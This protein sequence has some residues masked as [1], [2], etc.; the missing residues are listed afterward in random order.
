MARLQQPRIKALLF[1]LNVGIPVIVFQPVSATAEEPNKPAKQLVT[2]QNFL[3]LFPAEEEFTRFVESVTGPFS[4]IYFECVDYEAYQMEKGS[5]DVKLIVDAA[6]QEC[7]KYQEMM[8][9]YMAGLSENPSSLYAVS[10]G[11]RSDILRGLQRAAADRAAIFIL[12][13]KA[14]QLVRKP[15]D[16]QILLDKLIKG[17][18]HDLNNN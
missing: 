7:R 14:G 12:K 13:K 17:V 8:G 16:P 1:L 3:S 6:I 4:K 9:N 15:T 2:Q 11:L 5:A 18:E 10:A